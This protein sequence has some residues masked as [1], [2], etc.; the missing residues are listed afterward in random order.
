[1]PKKRVNLSR[2]EEKERKIIIN[3]TS[4]LSVSSGFFETESSHQI[5]QTASRFHPHNPPETDNVDM[6]TDDQHIKNG[7]EEKRETTHR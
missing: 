5:F 6:F 3:L 7:K 2:M 4:D 1:M